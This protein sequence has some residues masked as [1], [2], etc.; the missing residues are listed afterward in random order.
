MEDESRPTLKRCYVDMGTESEQSV[1]VGK[2]ELEG[3][4]KELSSITEELRWVAVRVDI[5]YERIYYG[6]RK[7]EGDILGSGGQVQQVLSE[8][9]GDVLEGHKDTRSVVS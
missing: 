3:W 6:T 1:S 9:Q 5:L 8:V 2:D 7:K 4:L